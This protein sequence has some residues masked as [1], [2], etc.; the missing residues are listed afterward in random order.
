MK[1]Y[2]SEILF[3]NSPTA[4]NPMPALPT[5]TECCGCA[6]CVDACPQN[7]LTLKEDKNGVLTPEIDSKLCIECKLCEKKCH[8]LSQ[9]KIK[10]VNP[11][12]IV[13]LYGWSTDKDLLHESASGGIF[14]QLAKDFLQF[15]DSYVYGACLNNNAVKHIEIDSVEDILKLQGSKYQQSDLTGIFKIVRKRLSDNCRVLFSGLPCHI[16]ALKVFLGEK[17]QNDNLYTIEVICHGLPT[18]Q[19]L[20]TALKIYS[21]SDILSYRNKNKGWGPQGNRVTFELKNDTILT[22]N[23]HE[24]DFLFRSYLTFNFSRLNCYN[25]KYARIERVADLTLGDFWG[26]D[27]A[28][29]TLNKFNNQGTSVILCNT[30]RGLNLI[31]ES[32]D[33]HKGNLAWTDFMYVN[34]NLYMPCTHYRYKG[35]KFV[36]IIKHLPLFLQKGIFQNGFK[37]R[38]LSFIYF[39]GLQLF[40]GSY[41]PE[42][43]EQDQLLHYKLALNKTNHGKKN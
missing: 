29:N 23:K 3:L 18:N 19:L 13:P 26:A 30:P 40:L 28:E 11:R 8:I 6:A 39:R 5:Y 27:K 16:A 17:F 9:E 14:A 37:N 22:F 2:L 43:I 38:L 20:K 4:S 36:G 33:L 34:Q 41:R 10:R 25:C 24:D 15:P 21:A 7:A 12:D 42:K 35:V 32:V 31:K 1:N